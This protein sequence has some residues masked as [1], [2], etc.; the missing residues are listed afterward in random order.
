M[1]RPPAYKLYCGE[2][3]TML[4]GNDLDAMI[5]MAKMHR[6]AL[7]GEYLIKDIYGNVVWEGEKDA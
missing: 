7:G 1:A 6:A 4:A 5:Q 2:L 3:A